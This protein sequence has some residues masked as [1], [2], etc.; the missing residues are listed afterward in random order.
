MVSVYAIICGV[1]NSAY[2]GCT[3]GKPAK[4]LREHRCLLNQGKHA[5]SAMIE[6]WRKYGASAFYLKIL[7][8]LPAG[9]AARV[10]REA[11]HR[12]MAHYAALQRLY[13]P[14]TLSFQ[15]SPEAIAKG[16]EASRTSVGNRWSPEANLKR[17]LAQLG[18]PKGHGAKIS[19]TKRAQAMR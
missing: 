6:D 2:V 1:N 10:K 4:R 19:A 11:E 3:A 16:V 5:A 14:N 12:W 17:R 18:K 7:E 13:N 15:L 9:S 8:K